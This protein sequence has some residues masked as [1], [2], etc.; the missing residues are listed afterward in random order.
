[1]QHGYG[2]ILAATPHMITPSIGRNDRSR[3]QLPIIV[4]LQV[5]KRPLE[6]LGRFCDWIY[7]VQL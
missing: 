7:I 6:S 5:G 2:I 4:T 1:M 3:Q